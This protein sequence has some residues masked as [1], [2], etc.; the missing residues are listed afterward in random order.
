MTVYAITDPSTLH[1]TTLKDDLSHFATQANMIVYRDKACKAYAQNAKIFLAHAKGFDRVLLHTD[2]L[3]ASELQ[4]D[5]VHLTSKQL[6]AIPKAK[7]LGLFVIVSTH[8]RDEAL[9]A[10]SMG[11]D[12][13]TFSPVFDTPNK[14]KPVGIEVLSEIVSCIDIPVLALG[15]IVTQEQINSCVDVGAEGF[16]SI[17]YFARNSLNSL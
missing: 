5:G 13:I 12:M 6:D 1:F 4:A 14:G 15:G 2:Y 3:L 17:R 16:G 11:A 10:E 9:K 7:A 8:T